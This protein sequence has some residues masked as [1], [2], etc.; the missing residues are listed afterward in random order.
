[1][2]LSVLLMDEDGERK[3]KEEVMEAIEEVW[4]DASI[5]SDSFSMSDLG[6]GDKRNFEEEKKRS[7][8]RAPNATTPEENAF[9]TLQK[10]V[11]ELAFPKT[12]VESTSES[13]VAVSDQIASFAR[14]ARTMAFSKRKEEEAADKF[15]PLPCWIEK[16]MD[17]SVRMQLRNVASADNASEHVTSHILQYI[18]IEKRAKSWVRGVD[19]DC[20]DYPVQYGRGECPCREWDCN[21]SCGKGDMCDMC[22]CQDSYLKESEL[23]PSKGYLKAV[24]F[25]PIQELDHFSHNQEEGLRLKLFNGRRKA[26]QDVLDGLKRN[27]KN[28]LT[29]KVLKLLLRANNVPKGSTASQ[30]AAERNDSYKGL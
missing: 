1:M 29:I 3:P 21:G 30:E 16:S 7:A 15:G 14:Q 12:L 9:Q 25:D 11:Q 24:V 28:S 20:D 4:E 13:M 5:I 8:D 6:S 10:Q 22:D 27:R 2:D 26:I 17:R 18:N 23:G 19:C